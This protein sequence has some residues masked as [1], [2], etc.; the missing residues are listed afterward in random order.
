MSIVAILF[1]WSATLFAQCPP[2]D[3]SAGVNNFTTQTEIDNYILNYPNCT[4][5]T[6]FVNIYDE[7][8]TTD[9]ITNLNG[10]ANLERI[11]GSIKIFETSQ[12]TDLTGLSG[13]T[14][15]TR[16][17]TIYDNT[18]LQ[19]LN[20][21]DNLVGIGTGSSYNALS[22][23]NNSALL[24]I[25]ALNQV[26]QG[27]L[28]SVSV[29][30]NPLLTSLSGLDNFSIDSSTPFPYLKILNNPMLS[31]CDVESVCTYISEGGVA[32]ISGNAV[33]CE[34]LAEVTSRCQVSFPNCPENNVL[35]TTQAEIDQFII[36]YPNCAVIP[37]T[38]TIND[39]GTDPIVNLNGL[40]NIETIYGLAVKNTTLTD[41]SGLNTLEF[42]DGTI[43]I[44][45]ISE[46]DITFLNGFEEIGGGI[47][48]SNNTALTDL[49]GFSTLTHID[50]PIEITNNDALTTLSGLDSIV[51]NTITNLIIE[52]NDVLSTCNM[53]VIC[54][55]LANGFPATISN[56]DTG[57]DTIT[58]VEGTC[59]TAE[60]PPSDVTFLTQ[61]E[62]DYF[63]L[64]YPNC[65]QLSGNVTIGDS[66]NDITSLQPLQ[67]ITTINGYLS[68][69]NTAITNFD[70]LHN[71]ETVTG[72]WINI[73]RN[74]NI[75]NMQG[76]D[77]L[78]SVSVE[79]IVYLNSNLETL[80]GLESLTTLGS[81]NIQNNNLLI[82]LD[83]LHN[84]GDLISTG[85]AD[86][87]SIYGNDSLQNIDALS[88]VTYTD[89]SVK[90]Q[91]NAVLQDISGLSNLVQIGS[92]S[93]FSFLRIQDNHTLTTLNLES[94]ETV[95]GKIDLFTN[96]GLEN[97]DG[98]SSLNS[99]WG[100][101]IEGNIALENIEGLS[102]L[103]NAVQP[104]FEVQV[105]E[106]KHNLA[107]TSLVGLENV[108]KVGRLEIGGNSSLI[109]FE[110]LDNL[111]EVGQ[112]FVLRENP[113]IT[114]LTGLEN[115][116]QIGVWPHGAPVPFLIWDHAA[117]TNVEALSNLI[118]LNNGDILIAGNPQLTSLSGLDNVAPTSISYLELLESKNL[119]YCEV[120]SICEFIANVPSAAVA[121]QN[122]A[123]GCN[124][125]L[126]VIDACEALGVEDVSLSNSIAIH[127]NPMQDNVTITTS[128]GIAI[129][130]VT[131]YDV[132]GKAV[133]THSG[134]KSTINVSSMSKGIYFIVVNTNKGTYQQKLVK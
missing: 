83:G 38:L 46:S 111:E 18:A 104:G 69:E 92:S 10:L 57:C 82:N 3:N 62:L 49:N 37:G 45:N 27:L 68:I 132:S 122:N 116:S 81:V 107:L 108:T 127:P 103:S 22:I 6:V 61:A 50:G 117:L 14:E 53:D 5:L 67:N 84:I 13:L 30:D 131:L 33:G 114:D 40:Q 28:N 72:S 74:D 94:L 73:S 48:L 11:D 126:E 85:N 106:I 65:T 15:I 128:N 129:E 32:Q 36:D 42:I 20:G 98:L 34:D 70:G 39:T 21:L 31:I 105:F 8:G 110:G 134:D 1:I 130:Q 88:G 121:I 59:D 56:N 87:I 99:V 102:N 71:L 9:P 17:V 51:A 124:S 4:E 60:C 43:E 90:I 91:N 47:I 12:L 101:T 80:T 58:Q 96:N 79:L 115:L 75:T 35:L 100:L 119:S 41:F 44:D 52:D 120:A 26:N 89:K 2:P 86:A 63:A 123:T 25:N 125:E 112:G 64:Q 66:P 19:S 78:A 93:D 118:S 76:F 133:H 109:S 23:Y 7:E 55:Y 54:I 24:D 97:L 29:N 95:N 16:G 77:S 113:L